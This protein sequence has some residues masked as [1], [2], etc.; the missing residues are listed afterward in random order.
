MKKARKD[1]GNS[2]VT[3][4]GRPRRI[5]YIRV[6]KDDQRLSL[7]LDAMRR[8]RCDLIFPEHG[9]SGAK[10]KRP[11]FDKAMAALRPGD[12]LV[13]WKLDRMGRSL[14]HLVDVMQAIEARGAHFECIT[15][16][17]DTSTAMG[18]FFFHVMAALAQLE[19]E[20]ISERT[21]AGLEAARARGKRLGRPKKGHRRIV[22]RVSKWRRQR[23]GLRPVFVRVA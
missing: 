1:I 14:R 22:V 4:E 12:T 11:E 17:I 15:D 6:S 21:R 10:G 19:R 18:K 13:V 3:D 20:L 16:A 7:Q 5:G 8:A 2:G 23:S 9:V